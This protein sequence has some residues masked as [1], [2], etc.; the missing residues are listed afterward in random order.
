MLHA[1]P[2]LDAPPTD[3]AEEQAAR[4]ARVLQG[5]TEVCMDVAEALREQVLEQVA[6]KTPVDPGQAA[7]ALS[8]LAR[9][10]RLTLMLEAMFAEAPAAADDGT[11]DDE[12]DDEPPK[13]AIPRYEERITAFMAVAGA[14]GTEVRGDVDRSERLRAEARERLFDRETDVMDRPIGEVVA[15]ICRDFGLTYDPGSWVD[16]PALYVEAAERVAAS[17]RATDN[18]AAASG[19]AQAP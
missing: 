11:D 16:M 6:A 15:L 2:S 4:H 3:P 18:D 8:R 7:L 17:V 9:A 1:P 10:V 5:L 13:A 12:D 19:R 14:I